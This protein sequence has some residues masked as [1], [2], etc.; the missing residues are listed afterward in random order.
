ML[1]ILGILIGA[2]LWQAIVAV[3][4]IVSSED[5]EWTSLIGMGAWFWAIKTFMMVIKFVIKAYCKKHSVVVNIYKDDKSI[6]HGYQVSK[7]DLRTL[8]TSSRAGFWLKVRSDTAVNNPSS[9]DDLK[10]QNNGWL[11]WQWVLDNCG[12]DNG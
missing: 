9:W 3:V 11:N 7:K 8:C 10:K 6:M 1:I 2:L 12:V 4:F 5:D